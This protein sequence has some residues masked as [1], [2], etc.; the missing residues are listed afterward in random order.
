MAPGTSKQK[1]RPIVW[2]E[3]PKI[4]RKTSLPPSVSSLTPGLFG[5]PMG[6]SLLGRRKNWGSFGSGP[7]RGAP[8]GG[9][10]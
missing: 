4:S 6:G 1:I 7:S 2:T 9:H 3:S 5:P 8:R 10:R